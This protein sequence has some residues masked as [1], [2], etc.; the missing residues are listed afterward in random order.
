MIIINKMGRKT[1]T[2]HNHTTDE[3][4]LHEE[5]EDDIQYK[6]LIQKENIEL[7][8]MNVICHLQTSLID[9]SENLSLSLCEH[10]DTDCV[11]DF[12]NHIEN[13]YH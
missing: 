1:R 9:Y 4:S 8:Y 13:M 6:T 12:I 10:M 5:P 7:L 3:H 2:K 11:Y